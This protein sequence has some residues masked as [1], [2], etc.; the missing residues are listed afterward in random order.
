VELSVIIVAYNNLIYT[1]KCLESLRLYADVPYEL[2]FVNN[3]ST[4]NTFNFV[5]NFRGS[6]Y[7]MCKEAKIITL[8]KNYRLCKGLNTGFKHAK[9][10]YIMM[11]DNDIILAKGT[12]S[13]LLQRLKEHPEYGAVSPNW[14]LKDINNSWHNFFDTPESIQT[15]MDEFLKIYTVP[16]KEGHIS[17]WLYG[18]CF[19]TS[20]EV[21]DEIG[22]W[23]ESYQIGAMDND[24]TW[25]LMW[26]GKYSPMV[27]TDLPCYHAG[28]VTRKGLNPDHAMLESRDCIY[29]KE[30]HGIDLNDVGLLCARREDKRRAIVKGSE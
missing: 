14:C 22:E 17:N 29:F 27:F 10:K 12:V 5:D 6:L 7:P 18:S 8:D 25:R 26:T 24:W 2:I 20:R 1:L 13:G 16:M 30:K 3:G 21:W 28:E 11:V 4:D 9:G 23:D 19:M 15:K